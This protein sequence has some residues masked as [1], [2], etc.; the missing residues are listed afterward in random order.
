MHK[1]YYFTGTG[2]TLAAAKQ[3]AAMLG[4]Q[5]ELIPIA[6]LAR[7]NTVDFGDA[8]TVGIFHPVYCFGIPA[9]VQKFLERIKKHPRGTKQPYLYSLCTSSGL[10]GSAHIILEQGLRKQGYKLNAYFHIPMVS[11]Y[12][13]RAKAPNQRRLEKILKSAE[14]KIRAAGEKILAKKNRRPIH[15]FPLDMFGEIAGMRAVSFMND[16][17]KYFWLNENC[18]GCELCEKICPASNI[19]IMNGM[20]TWRGHCEQCMACL[21]WCPKEAIQF[22]KITE[23]RERYHHPD[24][25][26]EEL[27][28]TAHSEKKK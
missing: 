17:D 16:Y 11:N 26:A 21:Q 22:R 27:F 10:L 23:K 15:V 20:P 24:I 28:R 4:E 8:E 1:I 6:S 14:K 3:I 12:I 2:N 25:K 13:P 5:M 9:I 7:G 18:N 19:I